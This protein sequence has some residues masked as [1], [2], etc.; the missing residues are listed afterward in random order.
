MVTGWLTAD[1]PPHEF[2][3]ILNDLAAPRR[4]LPQSDNLGIAAGSAIM[5]I[6]F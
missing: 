5:L 1:R 3:A 6:A 2:A 4:M